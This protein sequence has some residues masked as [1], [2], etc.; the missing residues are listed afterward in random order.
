MQ[1][2]DMPTPERI[3]HM[4]HGFQPAAALKGAIELGLFTALGGES[5]TAA[6]LAQAIGA[7]ERGV[8]ILCDFLTAAG[9]LEKDGSEYRSSPDCAMYLDESSPAY[10]GSVGRFILG[11]DVLGSFADIAGVVRKGGTLLEGQGTVEPN[12]PLWVEFARSMV[13][14]ML[15]A[16]GFIADLVTENLSADARLKV[17]DVAAGHGVFGIGILMQ[18]ANA[19][20][21]ALDWPIVL[22]VASENAEKAGVADRHRSLPGSA[23][24]VDFGTGYDV[25]LLTNF[26][27]HYDIPTCTKLMRKVHG[28]LKDGG[29]AVLLEFVPNEDRVSPPEQAFFALTMLVTTTSGDAYT[30]KQYESMA[31]DAGFSKSELH[32]KEG[33]NESVVVLT[34]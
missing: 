26:V 6:A 16:A 1:D 23:F 34:K 21:V 17:L 10:L 20:V 14:L 22:E 7:P 31:A 25:I 32:R 30:F 15:P 11:D 19:E 18:H 29:R 27:H 12:N 5:K 28:A 33:L 2:Q 24:D 3:L 13:P 9:L 4:M 8:R